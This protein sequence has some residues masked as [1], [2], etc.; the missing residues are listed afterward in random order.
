MCKNWTIR[1]C[2]LRNWLIL[3]IGVNDW[4][5]PKITRYRKSKISKNSENL[6]LPKVA[7]LHHVEVDNCAA[8]MAMW[9]CVNTGLYLHNNCSCHYVNTVI[10]LPTLVHYLGQWVLHS[11]QVQLLIHT[12]ISG[13]FE[14]IKISAV[15]QEKYITSRAYERPRP[16]GQG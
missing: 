2:A 9:Q 13:H 15:R 1:T 6:T 10:V 11:A 12:R 8:C 16:T 3:K 5:I 14:P 4:R 7:V